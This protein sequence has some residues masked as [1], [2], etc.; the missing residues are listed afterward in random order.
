M[1]TA[2]DSGKSQITGLLAVTLL[3]L[4]WQSAGGKQP[5]N[6]HCT[7]AVMEFSLAA[8]KSYEQPISGNLTFKIAQ[9]QPNGWTF[10]LE[11]SAGHDYIAPVNPPLRFNPTQIIGSGYG[12]TAQQSLKMDRGAIR[13]ILNEADY[14]RIDQL[15][16]YA[17]W[18]A[19]APDPDHAADNYVTAINKIKTGTLRLTVPKSD[20]SPDD[21]IR[22]ATFRIEITVPE[23]FHLDPALG[24]QPAACQQQS[25]RGSHVD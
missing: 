23:E 5:S 1:S 16:R 2:K 6:P 22:S 25:I 15:W 12:L 8:G 19:D 21:I 13:F 4:S 9:R 3:I 17:L 20:V 24:L 10:S 18:P 7:K 11:D 14:N